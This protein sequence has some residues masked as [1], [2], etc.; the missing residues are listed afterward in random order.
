[1]VCLPVQFSQGK[2]Q[3]TLHFLAFTVLHW[4]V[5]ALATHAFLCLSCF[6]SYFII[7]IFVV[8]FPVFFTLVGWGVGGLAVNNFGVVLLGYFLLL[9]FFLCPFYFACSIFS[10]SLTSFLQKISIGLRFV[11]VSSICRKKLSIWNS[12]SILCIYK[13]PR[14]PDN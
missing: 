5:L 11:V 9:S 6:F 12:S 10:S 2:L 7:F 3:K 8:S 4:I 1:M 13:M 14:D